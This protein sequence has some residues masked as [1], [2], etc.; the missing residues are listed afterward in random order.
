MRYCIWTVSKKSFV[1]LH[2]HSAYSLL[3]GACKVGNLVQRAAELEMPALAITDHGVM[4]GVIEFYRACHGAG[5]NPVIGSEAYITTGSR[6]TRIRDKDQNRTHHLVLLAEN[7]I[8]YRNLARLSSRAHTE[9]F[10]YKPRIDKELLAENSEGI[11]GLGACLQG[12]VAWNLARD[13]LDSAVLAANEYAEILGKDNFFLEVQDH[14]IAEQRKAN[15]LMPQVQKRT[16]LQVVA[17]NDVHYLKREHARAHE[18]LLCLQ[19]QTVLSDPKRMCYP[20]DEFYLKSREEMESLFR[21]F[22]NALD[23]SCEIAERCKVEIEF[24]TLHFPSFDCPPGFADGEAYLIHLADE[25]MQRLYNVNSVVNPKTDLEHKL[26]KRFFYELSVI[27]K[28]GFV[29]YFLVV[30][31]FIVYAKAQGIRVGPGR[32]SGAGSIMAYALGITGL[33]PLEYDLIFERFLNPERVSPPDFD[34][35]FCVSRRGEV[36]EYVKQKYGRDKVAQIATFGT[37]GAKSLMK[38]IGRVLEIPF[39]DCDRLAKMIPEEPKMTLQKAL[40]QSPDFK[41]ACGAD[42][43]AKRIM[44]YARVLEGLPRNLGM[45]AAGVVIGEHVLED[46]LPLCRDKS[47][48]PVTQYEKVTVEDIGLLKMDFLGLKNLTLISEAV[49]NIKNSTGLDLDIETVPL[50]DEATYKL[51]CAGDGVGVFQLESGGMRDLLTKLKPNCIQDL[52]AL[53]ALYRP[54]PMDMIPDF[55]DRKHGRVDITFDHPLLE[56][57]LSETYGVMIYQEQVQQA[58]NI[59]AGFSLGEGDILRRAMGK[60]KPEEMVKQRVKFI[61]GCKSTNNISATLAGN[62][63]DNIEKFAGYGFNKSHSAAYGYISY[64]TAYLKTH[65]QVDFIAAQLTMVMGSADDIP[66]FLKDAREHQISVLAPAI[67]ESR[68][69]FTPI[70]RTIRYG[71]TGIKGVGEV[72]SKSIVAERTAKGPFAG[73]IDFCARMDSSLVNKKALENLVRAGAFDCFELD[74]G[75]L[76]NGVE[77]AMARAAANLRDSKSGQGNLFDLMAPEEAAP[78]GDTELPETPPWPNIEKL[79]AEKELLGVY[80]SG[81]PLDELDD[82]VKQYALNDLSDIADCPDR[83]PTRLAGMATSVQKKFTRKGQPMIIMTLENQDTSIEAMCFDFNECVTR[84]GDVV[85]PDTALL[86]CGEVDRRDAEAKIKGVEIYP[87]LDA[88]RHFAT[89]VTLALAQ[90]DDPAMMAQVRD[91]LRLHPGPIPVF[92]KFSLADGSVATIGTERAFN[93]L[94]DAS[95]CKAM[96][97]LLPDSAVEIERLNTP[98]KHPPPKKTYGKPNGG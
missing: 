60:K 12:E 14:G 31:D 34:I 83:T 93:V 6:H 8:G 98:F 20:S 56:S 75:R 61:D 36:I 89:R 57:I 26:N 13:N 66:T 40:E 87:L 94:P 68:D 15:L 42:P 81:H 4:H 84:Y 86:F 50:D 21:D 49:E 16:G 76:F 79:R 91:Q 95:F 67:N 30:Q 32:G 27:K 41:Q 37:L 3:D 48:E 24:G 45:H 51:L 77:F 59:L 23:L 53:I 17:T 5:I 44:E 78:S 74:R 52:I 25:G 64:W 9:G 19:T 46:I 28:T 96:R 1:H 10:Y 33:D 55:I 38:D 82:L 29:D 11:I 58:S 7:D 2:T 70:E 72:A 88:P 65:H 18:I 71:L 22:P 69:R 85:Q 92:V 35:D 80:I 54:G 97:A 63:F 62:I 47:G 90:G 73:L 39:G 43:S